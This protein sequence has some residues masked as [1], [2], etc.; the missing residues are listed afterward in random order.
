MLI[1][2]LG[3]AIVNAKDGKNRWVKVQKSSQKALILDWN[4]FMILVLLVQDPTTCSSLH[5]PRGVS[6]AA[7]EPQRSGQRC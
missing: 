7:A 3:P 6:P 4:Y 1:D 5:R 2:T